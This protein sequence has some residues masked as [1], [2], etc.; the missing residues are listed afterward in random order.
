M[1]GELSNRFQGRLF[2]SSRR[3]GV[4]L[5]QSPAGEEAGRDQPG[6]SV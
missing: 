5:A 1:S 2:V 4:R 6:V 3:E